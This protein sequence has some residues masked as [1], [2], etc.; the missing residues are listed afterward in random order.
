MALFK[1][2]DVSK[3]FAPIGLFVLLPL[4]VWRSAMLWIEYNLDAG[5]KNAGLDRT[6]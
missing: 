5:R 2:V 1:S 3:R 4:V 6:S